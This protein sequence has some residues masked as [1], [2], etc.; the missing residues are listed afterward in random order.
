MV[1]LD[2]R[3][4][5]RPGA[6]LLLALTLAA[7]ARDDVLA[8]TIRRQPDSAPPT[9]HVL[10][11]SAGFRLDT[12][13][14]TIEIGYD[15]QGSGA[16]VVTFRALINELDYSAVFDHHSRGAT[17][18]IPKSRPLPIGENRLRVE[19]ADRA[20]NVGRTEV[21]FVNAGG[22]WLTVTALPGQGPRRHVDLVL[23]ASG[24]MREAMGL[25][26]RMAVAKT[27]IKALL[28]GLPADTALGLRVFRDCQDI[29]ELAPIQPIDK[30]QFVAKVERIEPTGGTPLVA[31]LLQS[32]DAL[33]KIP[34][35][36]RA[37][38]LVTDGGESCQGEF[39]DAINRATDSASRLIVIG[40]GI[41][42]AGVNAE[43]KRLAE[44]TGGAFFDARNPAELAHA[45]ERSVLRL[46]Y[47]VY[48]GEGVRVADG[49]VNGVPLE[50]PI[51]TYQVRLDTTPPIVVTN[52]N[53]GPLAEIGIAVRRNGSKLTTEIVARSPR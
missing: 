31:S 20:G 5:Y 44:R 53:V 19:L 32:F 4:V 51:G 35:G 39:N 50:L 22:G 49:A 24:S 15:D 13:T 38:V 21:T 12:A 1:P 26:N 43:L 16:A 6:R 9:I 48:T 2:P 45:L 47:G 37:T 18:R 40:F 34:D 41:E 23:D 29:V 17:G 25:S 27:A 46:T 52:V 14:P 7:V 30:T 33:A 8:Q 11:P 42:E 3:A 28:N 10:Q 36:E